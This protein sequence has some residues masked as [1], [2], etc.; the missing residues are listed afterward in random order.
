MTIDAIS[1]QIFPSEPTEIRWENNTVTVPNTSVNIPLPTA[2][3]PTAPAPT[4]AEAS[5]VATAIYEGAD[6]V[7]LSAETATGTTGRPSIL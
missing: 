3:A 6:A 4:R 2:A 1:V 5:D 7:M